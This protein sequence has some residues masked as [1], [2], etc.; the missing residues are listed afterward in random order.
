MEESEMSG[1]WVLQMEM[2]IILYGALEELDERG[3]LCG[4]IFK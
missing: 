4:N 2:N 3:L 1:N